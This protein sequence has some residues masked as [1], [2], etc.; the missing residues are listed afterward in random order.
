MLLVYFY[1]RDMLGNMKYV[2]C[3]IEYF[4]LNMR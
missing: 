1:K 2:E 3:C 4:S